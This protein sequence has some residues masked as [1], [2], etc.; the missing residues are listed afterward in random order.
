M[1]PL[2]IVCEYAWVR[3]TALCLEKRGGDILVP[4]RDSRFGVVCRED[5]LC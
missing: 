3:L 1:L 5:F 2:T 4:L